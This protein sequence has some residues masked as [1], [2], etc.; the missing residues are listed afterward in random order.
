MSA[1]LE[2]VRAGRVGETALLVKKLTDAER[3][4]LLPEL[5]AV[6][7]ELRAAPWESRSERG[8]PALQVAG[9]MCHSGA[10]A[11]ATWIAGADMRRRQAP[12]EMLLKVLADRDTG[13]Q[14]D[15]ARRLAAR[16]VSADVPFLLM[17]GLVR[18]SGCEVP[19]TDAYVVGWVRHIGHSWGRVPLVDRL[20]AEPDLAPL[21]TGLFELSDLGE[22][23]WL[24]GEGPGSWQSALAELTGAGVLERKAVVDACVARLL[25]GGGPTD[26]RVFLPLLGLLALTRDELRERVA[27]W[28]A[29]ARDAVSPV[30]GHA[31]SVLGTL[32]LDGGLTPRQLAE[33]SEGLLFRT[34]KKL[35]RA[36]LVLLGKVLAREPAAAAELLP[37][38]ARAF[39]HEDTEVQ[40]RALKLVERQAKRLDEEPAVRAGIAVAAEALSPALRVRAAAVLGI[41]AVAA[42]EA[43]EEVL[44]PPPEPV[45][46]MA[47]PDSAVELAEEVSALLAAGGDGDVAAFERALDGLARHAHRDQDALREALEP[48]AATRWWKQSESHG[49]RDTEEYFGHTRRGLLT[50]EGG[51]ELVLGTLYGA[52]STA[53][54]LAALRSGPAD[55]DCAR[56]GF[57]RILDV[58]LREL[59]HRIRTD[60]QPLLLATPSWSTGLLEPDELVGRLDTYRRL[61]ARVGEA[62]F[63]QALLRVRRED[64]AAALAA[65]GRASALGTPEG[66]R[67]ARLLSA[68]AAALPGCDRR[69]SGPRVLVESGEVRELQTDFP[70]AFR[71]LGRPFTTSDAVRYC[72]HWG[73]ENHRHWLATLPEL[74]ELVAVRL[75]HDLSEAALDDERGAGA[76]LPLLA[77]SGGVAG[78]STH[79]CVAYGLGARHPEDRLAA[80]DALL[81]LAA[82]GQ[83]DAERLG[84]DLGQL[85]RRGAV[86]PLRLA[87][88]ARTA[89]ATGANTTI[90]EMLRHTLPILLAGLSTEGTAGAPGTV[91]GLGELLSVAADC[92]E[93][94]G[95]RGELPHLTGAAAR[96]GSARLVVQARRLRDALAVA[97]AA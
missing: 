88:S 41:A 34:E 60:P 54:L 64:R 26:H 96:R 35:V 50:A 63:A 71:R 7:K 97:E 8:Y 14:A 36:Q 52:V 12:A 16:P 9:A 73:Q 74:R 44:P 27:D 78:E 49:R 39:G 28:T 2:A 90:W 70:E 10:A 23:R 87:E 19:V 84:A 94:S 18:R 47:A 24:F 67:L 92:A 80:V 37:A 82:R 32:A 56:H 58:R 13:W 91:R 45:R 81:V 38:V 48:V 33:A 72:C 76:V 55:H 6:R 59:A 51:L 17:A 65:A 75:V 68:G 11:A 61:G 83:L 77:E 95:A 29:L 69:T 20:R 25:R 93:R 85:V 66:D 30:A 62:D 79:L 21:V 89:A 22:V 42:P 43:Y 15:V 1:V 31:Q 53:T 5:Q 4:A 40:E 3:R 86:K 46:L 57:S